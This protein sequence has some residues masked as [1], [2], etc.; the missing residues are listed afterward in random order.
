MPAHLSTPSF[1]ARAVRL[2]AMSALLLAGTFFALL[3]AVRLVVFPAVE[4]RR[5][6]IAQWMAKRVGQPVELDALVTGWDGWNPK[7]SVRG[8]RVRARGA[9]GSGLL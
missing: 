6:D 3:L 2:V 1:A 8:F 9:G 5:D 4:A 7:L